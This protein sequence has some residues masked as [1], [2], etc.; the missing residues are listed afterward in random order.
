MDRSDEITAVLRAIRHGDRSGI[1]RLFAAVY[2]ELRKVSHAQRLRWRGD[3]T[4][5]TT[6]LVHEAYLKLIRQDKVEWEDRAHF[7]AVAAT[8]MRHILVNY[9]EQRLAAKRGGGAVHVPLDEANPVPTESA[10]ELLALDAALQE[11]SSANERHGRVVECRFFGGLG[12]GE[13]AEALGVSPATVSRDWALASAWLRR[14]LEPPSA[15][16]G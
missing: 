6:A 2:T 8:A 16:G 10:E 14:A 7:F 9:A 13:T 15:E 3:E 1:D 5:N 11:L 4:L 12:I